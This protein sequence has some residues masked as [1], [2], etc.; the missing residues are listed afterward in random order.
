[1]GR[2]K[3][4]FPF[5]YG[6]LSKNKIVIRLHWLDHFSLLS[7]DFERR[8]WS[9]NS[10]SQ[11]WLEIKTGVNYRVRKLFLIFNK[12]AISNRRSTLQR[13]PLKKGFSV[14]NKKKT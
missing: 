12:K 9:M 10:W 4:F 7:C 8:I 2:Y 5:S 13:L 3:T 6:V 14:Q 11:F 1:M